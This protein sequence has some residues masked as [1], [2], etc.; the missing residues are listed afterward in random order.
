MPRYTQLST[1]VYATVQALDLNAKCESMHA[2]RQNRNQRFHAN[3]T[4]N[5]RRILYKHRASATLQP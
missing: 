3:R 2:S 4:C 5:T 1:Y